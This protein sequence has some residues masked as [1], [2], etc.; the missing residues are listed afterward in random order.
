MELN[1]LYTELRETDTNFTLKVIDVIRKVT[2]EKSIIKD[3]LNC[4]ADKRIT[5]NPYFNEQKRY[6]FLARF[7]KSHSGY[8]KGVFP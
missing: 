6:K 3:T 7:V 1:T 8:C 2:K 4:L 5:D